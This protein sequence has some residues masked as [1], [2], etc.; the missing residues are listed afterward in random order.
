MSLYET[1]QKD[2]R[3]DRQTDRQ[4]D[5]R[6]YAAALPPLSPALSS[7]DTYAAHRSLPHS[8]SSADS[9]TEH[10]ESSLV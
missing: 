10:R 8:F 4:A 6:T 1:L 5:R 7:H 3:T 2:R 9:S